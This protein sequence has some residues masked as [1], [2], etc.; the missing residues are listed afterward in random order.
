MAATVR[1]GV[2]A[3]IVHGGAGVWRQEDLER[4]KGPLLEAVREGF[5]QA[6][7]GDA[8]DMVV[9]AVAVLEDSEVF[10]AGLGSVLDISGNLTMDAAVMR[11]WD[12]A[13]GAVAA[14][15]Y[16]K[17]PVRLARAVLERTPH[18]LIVGP[19]ADDLARRLGL[20]RHPG[21]SRRTL[22]RWRSIKESKGGESELL[23]SW[24]TMAAQLGFDT[25]GAVAVDR[26]GRLAAAVS[27]GGVMMKLPGRVGDSPIAGAGLYANERVAVAGT[28]VGEFIMRLGLSLRIAIMYERLGDLGLSVANGVEL[29]TS[30]F[31]GGTGG[32]IALSRDGMGAVDYNTVAMPWKAAGAQ[33][34][35]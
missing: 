34:Q 17:N 10:D 33:V 24:I 35:P 32:F 16:P 11:G 18:S 23:R 4:A 1:L 8:V 9:E 6:A 22:E 29:L 3:I 12:L 2:P 14:V 26:E 7:R 19:W 5:R 21:P 30:R 20:E 31:G 27:T 13:V 28:G 15:S 25:V